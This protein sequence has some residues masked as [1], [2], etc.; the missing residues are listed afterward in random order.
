MSVEDV[1]KGKQKAGTQKGSSLRKWSTNLDIASGIASFVPVIGNA[2]G[3][4]GGTAG[5]VGNLIADA[6]DD[7]VSRSEMMRNLAIN[8]G[9]TG[10]MLIP[11]GGLVK[12]GKA[13]ARND[14]FGR[15]QC[16][17]KSR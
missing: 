2:I 8:A 11:G 9:M 5:T 3:A 6:M 13:A 16:S 15:L 12:A 10:L 4:I 1:K 7:S 14:R 17:V